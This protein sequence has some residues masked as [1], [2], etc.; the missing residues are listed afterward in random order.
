MMSDTSITYIHRSV[1]EWV[2]RQ[3]PDAVTQI[4][5]HTYRIYDRFFVIS[6]V[7]ITI[8]EMV[9]LMLEH[10]WDSDTGEDGD[11]R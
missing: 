8:A 1:L 7:N 2:Q 5:E 6:G 9:V 10:G 3:A 11:K 4:D